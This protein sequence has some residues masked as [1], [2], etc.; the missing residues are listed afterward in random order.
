V[1]AT[2]DS[3][4]GVHGGCGYDTQNAECEML[5]E[6]AYAMDLAVTNTWFRKDEESW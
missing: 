4:E 5:L 6:F 1:G 3:F 2:T